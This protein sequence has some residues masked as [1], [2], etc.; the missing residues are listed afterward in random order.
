MWWAEDYQEACMKLAGGK[1][2]ITIVLDVT[3][4]QYLRRARHRIAPWTG[5]KEA[6]IKVPNLRAWGLAKHDALGY[7]VLIMCQTYLWI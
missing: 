1:W 6:L 4:G 2:L 7:A 5:P 3:H